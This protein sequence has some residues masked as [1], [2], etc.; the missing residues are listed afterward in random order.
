MVCGWFDE[1]TNDWRTDNIELVDGSGD[2]FICATTHLTIFGAIVEVSTH[3][4][5]VCRKELQMHSIL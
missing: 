5:K 3:Y 4:Q 1:E 2:N